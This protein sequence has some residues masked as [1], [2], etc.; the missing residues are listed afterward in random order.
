MYKLGE[1]VLVR[2]QLVKR[3]VNPSVI[4][5]V[6][7]AVINHGITATSKKYDTKEFA[8]GKSKEGIIVGVR[9]IA[10]I[11]E[12][13][14]VREEYVTKTTRKKVY[15][16]ATNLRGLIYV[17]FE[18]ATSISEIDRIC[19]EYAILELEEELFGAEEFDFDEDF[20]DE[21]D[22]DDDDDLEFDDELGEEYC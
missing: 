7:N 14:A 15:L 3:E 2:G 17:P 13:Y 22:M 10:D 4:A 19:R 8:F 1:K 18:L 6:E 9:S 5:Q 16:V 20:L 11:R 12:H 21:M